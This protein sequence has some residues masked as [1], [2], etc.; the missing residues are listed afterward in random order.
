MACLFYCIINML[1]GFRVLPLALQYKFFHAFYGWK[2][3]HP[4]HGNVAAECF[5]HFSAKHNCING[6]PSQIEE[7][8]VNA[9]GILVQL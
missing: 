4:G 2:L 8:S 7:I 6:V 3:E 5:V 1:P 9:D